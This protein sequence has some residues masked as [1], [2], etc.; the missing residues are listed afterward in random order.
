MQRD[1]MIK[2]GIAALLV[3]GA[4]AAQ[5]QNCSSNFTISGG[6]APAISTWQAFPGLSPST[7]IDNLTRTAHLNSY[8]V[9]IKVNRR[10]GLLTALNDGARNGRVQEVKMVAR[11]RGNG[12]RVDYTM[13][14][15]PGQI[16]GPDFRS[17]VCRIV[18]SAVGG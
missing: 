5:A 6:L 8:W 11:K 17:D 18:R 10:L 1:S 9:S 12:T 14:L 16:P 3:F 2:Y 7:A 13:I 15:N 4:T